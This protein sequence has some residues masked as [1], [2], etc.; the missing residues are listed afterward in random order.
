MV[1]EM[2][3]CSASKNCLFEVFFAFDFFAVELRLLNKQILRSGI[4]KRDDTKEAGGSD[5][6]EYKLF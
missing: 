3:D 4:E 1:L 6:E 2:P 5:G